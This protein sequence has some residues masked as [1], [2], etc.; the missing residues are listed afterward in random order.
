MFE[1]YAITALVVDVCR[2]GVDGRK[3][4]QKMIYVA[5]VLGYP[6]TE[7]FTLYLYG[8]YSEE[9]AGELQCMKELK[10]LTENMLDS[11]YTIKLTEN[12]KTFLENFRANIVQK[13]GR[14]TL[15]K[16]EKLLEELSSYNPWKLELIATLFYFYHVG[17][18]DFNE[19]QNVV[20]R[21]KPKFSS[22]EIR[23]MTEK[24]CLLNDK[25]AVH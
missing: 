13:M 1:D 22:E 16:M 5:K 20:R 18:R 15:E 12:G 25:F 21:V 19:L 24:V 6:I 3:K 8:P 9:L 23:T 2:N 14:E 7:D 11:S 17:Y 4:L 10:I